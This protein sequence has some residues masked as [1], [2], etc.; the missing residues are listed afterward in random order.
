VKKKIIAIIQ[1][2]SGSSRLKNKM[3]LNLN[4]TKLIEWVFSRIKKSLYIDEY[5]LAT[6]KKK[7]DGQII[8]IAK[9]FGFK[10]FRGNDQKVLQR[11]YLAASKYKADIIVRICADNPLV[12]HRQIDRLIKF[13]L[14]NKFDYS[15]N[16]MRI[17]DNLNVDGF[18]AEIFSFKILK[19]VNQLAKKISDIEH[20]TQYIRRKPNI[21]KIASVPA[22]SGLNFPYLKFE[23][24]TKNDFNNIKKNISDLKIKINSSGKQIVKNIMTRK[25]DQNL[26]KLF[27]LNR[28]ITGKG[29]LI[30]LNEVKKIIP[31]K[32]LKIPSG[33]KVYDWKI[34][35]EWSVKEA[36]IKDADGNKIVDYEDSNLSVVNYSSRF[37]GNLSAKKLKKKLHYHPYMKTAIPYKTTYY[38]KDWG[39]CV[40]KEI[41]NKIMS[42]KKK[43]KVKIDSN[44][45]KGNLIYGELLI[46]GKSKKEILISTYICHPSM[47]NDNLSGVILCAHLSKFILSLKNRY[48]SYRIVFLPETIGAIAYCKLNEEKIR[49]ID[50]GLVI[51]NVGGKS[52]FSFK[53]SYDNKHF[54]NDIIKEVFQDESLKFKRYSFDINGSDERQYSSQ[55]FRLN[56]CSIFKDKYYE[57]KEY[58]SSKD[59]LEFVKSGNIFKSLKIY[60]KVIEK[61]E[62]QIIY[63]SAKTKCEPMLSKYNLYPKLGGDILPGRKKLSKLEI[64]LWLLFLA[65]GTKTLHQVSNQ[66][67]L[68]KNEVLDLYQKL[69][70]KKLITRE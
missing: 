4:G 31:I 15:Y 64:V 45:K 7:E 9:R 65:D 56:I 2:R 21:F 67:N 33:K 3:L 22:P 17:K 28:S 43:L 69:E 1:A 41:Y 5:V 23:V 59:N 52:Q 47:A 40:S 50:F 34:P 39:F 62:K 70:K 35:K 20:V 57:F 58:H 30:T 12:D 60:Q 11:F 42:C 27:P 49:N 51:C 14:K 48:W 63:K 54:I 8:K 24:N 26:I 25:I 32:I 29:N 38:N 13:Y 53:E 10:T 61:I 6:T 18:G 37:S 16:N 46:K 44:F 19:K 68:K 36:W 55:F 66:L